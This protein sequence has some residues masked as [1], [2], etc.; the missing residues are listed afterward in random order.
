MTMAQRRHQELLDAISNIDRA[1]DTEDISAN[2]SLKL[3]ALAENDSQGLFVRMIKARLHF[4]HMP[5]RFESIPEAHQR[6]FGWIYD[7]NITRSKDQPWD[8][9]THWLRCG[10]NHLYWITGNLPDPRRLVNLL[11]SKFR[12]TWLWQKHV[13]EIH[14]SGWP[15][16]F[17]LGGLGFDC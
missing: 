9:F 1:P 6:T 13:D 17:S 16:G 4:V 7:R 11:S 2:F 15:Y 3:H 5:D 14:P 10:S 12:K 8:N